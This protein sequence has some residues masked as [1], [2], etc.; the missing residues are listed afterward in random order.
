M[1]SREDSRRLAQLDRQLRRDDPDFCERMSAGGR[2]IRRRVPVS[3]A[4]I[5]I[6][7]WVSA[8]IL[9]VSGWWLGATVAITCAIAIAATVAYRN[10]RSHLGDHQA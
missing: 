1:L 3:V 2:P 10:R 9:A 4:L 7:V 5:A 6:A 8:L